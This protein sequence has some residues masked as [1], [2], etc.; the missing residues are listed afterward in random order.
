MVSASKN[1]TSCQ[2]KL[3]NFDIPDRLPSGS[4]ILALYSLTLILRNPLILPV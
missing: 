4:F 1:L 3:I 2:S